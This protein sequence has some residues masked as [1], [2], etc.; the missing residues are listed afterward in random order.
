MAQTGKAAVNKRVY[1]L[2]GEKNMRLMMK[3]FLCLCLAPLG[4][5]CQERITKVMVGPQD[6]QFKIVAA[7]I[8]PAETT[9]KMQSMIIEMSP[10][11]DNKEQPKSV[12]IDLTSTVRTLSTGEKQ[13]KILQLRWQK[14][15][16]IE[17]RCDGKWKKQTSNAATDKIVEAAKALFE[18]IP[19]K[20]KQPTEI[21]LTPAVEQQILAIFDTLNAEDFPCLRELK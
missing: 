12:L 4:V 19:V 2:K 17:F 18:V 13:Q 21:T 14:P 15:G 7:F 3:I 6:D 10:I 5:V 9:Y 8:E 16:E 11:K 20:A 1:L